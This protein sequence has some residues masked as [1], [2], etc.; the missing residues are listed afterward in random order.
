M[1]ERYTKSAEIYD[2]VYSEVIDYP[3]TAAQLTQLIKERNPDAGT[4]LEAA[5]GTGAVIAH[6][7]D[8]FTVAG[9]DL[10]EDMVRVAKAKLPTVEVRVADMVDFDW[11]STFDVVI[12]MFSSVGYLR[13]LADL[14]RA[15]QRFA[16]HIAPGGV[17]VVEPWFRP[18]Q[19]QLDHVGTL[20]ASANDVT[21]MRMNTSWLEDDGRLSVMDMHHLVGQPGSVEH[22]VER[23]ALSLVTPE[24]HLAAFAAAGL[25]MDYDPEGFI[26]RGLYVGS[27]A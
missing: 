16:A 24:E 4:L 23:H 15:Y 2:I 26:G 3:T 9:F 19:W 17:L 13:T 5:C 20:V 6:L 18:E 21:V 7:Q 8:D 22:F 12:C 1:T 27:L 14:E 10:S 11:G 25:A